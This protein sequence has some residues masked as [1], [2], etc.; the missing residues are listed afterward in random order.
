MRTSIAVPR[1]RRAARSSTCRRRQ[2]A[3]SRRPSRP[4]EAGL[5][6]A[7]GREADA[8]VARREPHAP[9]RCRKL[10]LSARGA[11]RAGRCWSALPARC[12]RRRSSAR[13]RQRRAP[14]RRLASSHAM[15]VRWAKFCTSHSQRRHEAQVVEHQR[16][17][18]GRRSA[19]STATVL[20]EQ[21][22]HRARAWPRRLRAARR[23]SLAQPRDVHLQRGE[24]LPE[25]VVQL[26]RDAAL[27]LLA[28][29]SS[30]RAELAAAPPAATGAG[31][32]RAPRALTSRRITV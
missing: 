4:N 27:L 5:R 7:S 32:R 10:D 12:G 17:Q 1:A 21:R 15:P 11:W 18:V 13:A 26:A 31:P 28:R 22:L 25:L 30:A 23:G 9:S 3:R 16:A 24:R 14:D 8:V 20:V 29:S 2:V 19:A 6:G